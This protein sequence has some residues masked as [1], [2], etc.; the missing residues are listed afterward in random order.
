M[1][2]RFQ[3]FYNH[4]R[5]LSIEEA[6]E[7]FSIFGGVEELIDININSTLLQTISNNIFKNFLQYNNIIAPSYLTKKPYRDVLMAIS[8]GDGR[9]SNILKR[10]HIYDSI[11]IEVIYELIELN[12]LREEH[13]REQPIKRNPKQK[14]KKHLRG[15]QIESKI[16]FVEPFY[17]FWFGFIEPFK[18]EILNKNYD[19]FYEYFNLHYNRLISLIFEQ[20]SN[21]IINYKFETISS[22][23]YWNRDSEFD[24]LS[25]TKNRLFFLK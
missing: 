5:E 4:N 19:N 12:I 14:L 7:C 24:I 18:D 11:A 1:K 20:L 9:V 10:S 22:G 13:S 15:Y 2:L 17:R 16:R 3:S 6:I 23:S 25:I 21:E 8:N